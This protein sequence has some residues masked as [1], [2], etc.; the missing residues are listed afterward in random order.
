MQSLAIVASFTLLTMMLGAIAVSANHENDGAQ[1]P[2]ANARFQRT[3]DRTDKPVA[4]DLVERTW[5][6]GPTFTD[7][8]ME[9]YEE[10]PGGMRQ[11]QYFDKSR[12]EDN[13]YRAPDA[14]WDVTNGLLVVEMVEGHFQVGDQ[15]FDESPEPAEQNVAGDPAGEEGMS[16]TY[17]DINRYGLRDKPATAPG[18]PLNWWIDAEG[19]ITQG[20]QPAGENVTAGQRVTVPNIDHTVA[21]VFWTYL[22]SSGPVWE[23]GQLVTEPL[24]EPWFYATG[25]P[26]TEAYWSNVMVERTQRAVLWQC[27]ERRC[28]TYT[29]GNSPGFLVEAGNVGQHYFRW[30]KDYAPGPA[31]TLFMAHLT[32]AQEV[33]PVE[34]EASGQAFFYLDQTE[35]NG[36]TSWVLRYHI[37]IADLE[38]ATAAHIHTAAGGQIGPPVAPISTT[39]TDGVIEG[40]ITEDDLLSDELTLLELVAQMIAGTTYVN[41]HTADNPNGEIRGQI[42]VA[43]SVAF[44]AHL[45]GAEEVPPVET[46]ATGEAELVYQNETDSLD[47]T[48]TVTGIDDFTASHIH[49]AAMGATGQVVAPLYIPA[50]PEAPTGPLDCDVMESELTGPLAGATIE[51]LVWGMIVGDAYVNVHSTTVGS[52]EIRGQIHL[53]EAGEPDA[54]EVL[55]TGLNNPRGIDFGAAGAVY[56]AQAGA[57]GTHCITFGEGD[58]AMERCLGMTGAVSTVAADG[59]VTDVIDNL[60]SV[61]FGEEIVGT[62]DVLV[63]GETIYALVGIGG[64]PELRTA[65]G[66]DAASLGTLVMSDG[67]GGWDVVAD[68]AAYEA[69]ANPDGG[70]ID[71][72]PYSLV[73]LDDGSFVVTDAGANALFHVAANG[74]VSTIAVFP[75][76]PMEFPPGTPVAMQAVPTG[77]AVGPDGA[78]YV[79][80]LTG[81]PFPVGGASVWRVMD[82]NEDGDMADEGEVTEYADGFTNIIDVAFD[83]DGELYVLE[84]AANSLLNVNPED[85]A[86]LAGRLVVVSAD[87]TSE[88]TVLTQGLVTPA[89]LGIDADG[90]VY[91]SNWG[92][93]TGQGQLVL[94]DHTAHAQP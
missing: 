15:E 19:E 60:P 88:T 3:W 91:V 22:N 53:A 12:M 37:Q 23:N 75:D 48:L 32:G 45:I 2:V 82:E 71:S 44:E 68:I 80:Q 5:M 47:C 67:E 55:A 29:P 69:A 21:S 70:A 46:E 31:E 20:N 10:A 41:F 51:E 57:G 1:H 43:D 13:S 85:P 6:W 59:T 40:E 34:T 94:L 89:G 73:M 49:W 93:V 8:M 42:A 35:D 24:F 76:T 52:G 79:G 54:F 61:T 64:P 77:V 81:F 27:F 33:P 17:A 11:V 62:Q 30:R 26:I 28:L 9:P 4:D 16:P 63:D 66:A 84:I 39:A 83:A 7:G 50:A 87:G 58:Q 86:T 36:A 25:L 74:T 72:N 14:P 38:G 92:V 56:V 18:T 90:M 65:L 78:Y